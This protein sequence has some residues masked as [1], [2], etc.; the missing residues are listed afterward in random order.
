MIIFRIYGYS[1]FF[2]DFR[3]W[4]FLL[5]PESVMVKWTIYYLIFIEWGGVEEG[6]EI[7]MVSFMIKIGTIWE[8]I[9]NDY[10]YKDICL[11]KVERI[12]LDLEE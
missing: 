1:I 12:G 2:F 9:M 8:N 5:T 4:F 11:E 10:H 7:N 3:F 6:V